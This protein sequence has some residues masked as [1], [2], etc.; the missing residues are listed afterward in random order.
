M[1]RTFETRSSVR[2]S[3]VNVAIMALQSKLGAALFVVG[4][5][6]Q[7]AFVQISTGATLL[8]PGLII[9]ALLVGVHAIVAAFALYSLPGF[10]LFALAV[11]A[12]PGLAGLAVGSWLGWFS[13]WTNMTALAVA[14]ATSL[15]VLGFMYAARKADRAAATSG[16]YLL[17]DVFRAGAVAQGA[18]A[19]VAAKVMRGISWLFFAVLGGVNCFVVRAVRL[20]R[21]GPRFACAHERCSYRSP[22][23]VFECRCTGEDRANAT[24]TTWPTTERPL[25]ACCD[26][27]DCGRLHATWL[28][29]TET[30][31]TGVARFRV[32][33][34]RNVCTGMCENA[35]KPLRKVAL[36]GRPGAAISR[37]AAAVRA[38]YRTKF[39]G[40]NI[41]APGFA[42]GEHRS[43]GWDGNVRVL[44]VPGEENA[45][46]ELDLVVVN[47]VGPRYW[48]GDCFAALIV[49]EAAGGGGDLPAEDILSHL[50]VATY[51]PGGEDNRATDGQEFRRRLIG[52]APKEGNNEYLSA[53]IP[54]LAIAYSHG[55]V[56][57]FGSI[58]VA[59][60]GD[61]TALARFLDESSL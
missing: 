16:M 38:W 53:R 56:Q 59:R 46:F 35:A 57:V 40:R 21:E 47:V 15:A 39:S 32:S 26:S 11:A 50:Y 19:D 23:P 24:F 42:D 33:R 25:L 10:R 49:D 27:T 36:L 41:D 60:L 5:L 13:S 12:L 2:R 31:A 51:P 37:A 18:R 54:K 17:R 1:S 45:S 9:A 34:S 44:A 22:N 28:S 61:D 6:S 52:P 20:S 55:S 14:T 43:L 4:L 48:I 3:G 58:E 8:S 30:L 7:Q 29:P